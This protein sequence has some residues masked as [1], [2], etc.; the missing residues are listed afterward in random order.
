[1]LPNI[2]SFSKYFYEYVFLIQKYVFLERPF[3][4]LESICNCYSWMSKTSSVQNQLFFPINYTVRY[5]FYQCSYSF[6]SISIKSDIPQK[7]N[8]VFSKVKVDK[9]KNTNKRTVPFLYICLVY[10]CRS[11]L[12]GFL[13]VRKQSKRHNKKYP[14]LNSKM[15][16]FFYFY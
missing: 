2:L 8:S 7:S 15:N 11:T 16:I 3:K 4:K 13:Q 12:H 10:F 5:L 1:M 14:F 9:I 6:K